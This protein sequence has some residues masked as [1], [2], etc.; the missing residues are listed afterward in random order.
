MLKE[1]ETENVQAIILTRKNSAAKSVFYFNRFNL[2]THLIKL[3]A[4][5]KASSSSIFEVADRG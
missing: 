2:V 4:R 3:A 5:P 1:E